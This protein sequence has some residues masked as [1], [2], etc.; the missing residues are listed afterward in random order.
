MHRLQVSGLPQRKWEMDRLPL[1]HG[2]AAF[3]QTGGLLQIPGVTC[4]FCVNARRDMKTIGSFGIQAVPTPPVGLATAAPISR[5]CT[6][7]RLAREWKTIS[8]MVRCYCR[9]HHDPAS[10]LCPDCQQLL[11][12]AG[13]RLERC[14]FG[15]GKPA[16]AK[17]PV[18]CYQPARR[19]LVKEVMRYAGPRMLW[20]HPVLSVRHWLDGFREAP[21]IC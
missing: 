20:Q 19:E 16:C 13:L 6:S 3:G 14:R 7:K 11:D 9:A 12:Y 10:A 18:H 4:H 2:I 5:R 8:A 21:A 1:S 15:P 17:C